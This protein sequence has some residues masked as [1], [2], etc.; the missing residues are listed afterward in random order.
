MVN[1]PDVNNNIGLVYILLLNHR[2]TVKYTVSHDETK[3]RA[4][5][6]QSE[7][8]KNQVGPAKDKHQ[9]QTHQLKLYI[10]GVIELKD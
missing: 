1:K 8:L 3:R 2:E 5:Y 4:H 6:L 7:L 9:A 10:K